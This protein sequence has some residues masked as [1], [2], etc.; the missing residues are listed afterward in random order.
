MYQVTVDWAP[1][2]EL[3][4]S[5]DAY[6]ATSERKVMDLG[7]DWVKSVRRSLPPA[8]EAELRAFGPGGKKGLPPLLVWLCPERD[9]CEGFIRWLRD[10]TPGTLYET[11]VPYLRDDQSATI[12]ELATGLRERGCVLAKW[13]EHYFR[14]IDAE[15]AAALRA[16]A[17][18]TSALGATMDAAD[19]VELA[20]NGIRFL[21]E[22]D[23]ATVLLIPQ[24]HFQ[25]WN[26][27]DIYREMKIYLYPV[28]ALP[29]PAGAPPRSLLRL[30]R[31]L[32]DDTRLRILRF[33]SAGSKGFT[34]ITHLTGLAKSTVH[35]HLVALRAAGLVRVFDGDPNA[36]RYSLRPRALD[37]LGRYLGAYLSASVEQE[38]GT[39]DSPQ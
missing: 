34:E 25:P 4:I 19:L 32:S 13:N 21:P 8:F 33:L 7:A 38:E 22:N 11:V 29:T 27:Y 23:I 37:E 36:V 20:T 15:I 30:T 24:Y 10:L 6:L 2:Y 28:D 35:H 39:N 26:L 16:S 5:L 1:A 17:R 14:H 3:V 9:D 12:R 31:A 18:A